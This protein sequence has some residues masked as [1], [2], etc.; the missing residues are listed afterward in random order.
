VAISIHAP[1][2]G[3]TP[4]CRRQWTEKPISIQAPVKGATSAARCRWPKSV[5]S[6]HAPVKGATSEHQYDRVNLVHF[7][8]RT[9]EG[10]DLV[11]PLNATSIRISIHAP[12]KG[13]TCVPVVR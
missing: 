6:I 2:K 5:I 13:A 7:N 1:V 11:F 9:R 12:V 8:P 4:E 3:A 10:C